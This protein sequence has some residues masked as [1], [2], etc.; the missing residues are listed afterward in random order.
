MGSDLVVA[1]GRA[2][3]N[4]QTLLGQNCNRPA[5]EGLVLRRVA[6]R[7]FTP[8]DT[9]TTVHAELPQARRTFTVLGGQIPGAWGFLHGVNEYRL[10]A[11]CAPWRSKLAGAGHGLLGTD[12]VRLILER[13]AGARQAVGVLTD[14]LARHGQAGGDNVFLIADPKEAF[15]VEAAGD[16]WSLQEIEQVRAAGD[17]AVIRQDW[18]R[19]APGLAG[20][21]IARGW[22]PEDGSKLDFAGTLSDE[23]AGRASALRRWGRATLLLE[24]QNGHI[25]AAFLRRLLADHYEGT[26]YE[27]DP[28]DAFGRVT[29]LCQH[30]TGGADSATAAS[31]VTVLSADPD[32]GPVVW[33]AFGPPCLSVHFPVFLDADLPAAFT[34]D[35]PA[36]YPGGVSW[37]AR[38]LADSVGADAGRIDLVRDAMG[39]LQARFEQEAEECAASAAALKRAGARAE[40]QRLAGSLMQNHL[41]R[42]D[43]AVEALLGA[44]VGPLPAP[45]G[46]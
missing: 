13:A 27:I 25:D 3:V 6:G 12:L 4:G 46:S 24:Q 32:R 14:L 33:C 45:A 15:A 26:R 10:A 39:R 2:T 31:F 41:E 1:L 9:L 19:I 21:V 34:A 18:N 42:F 17:V 40:L 23:P 29:P 37:L 44:A 22:W 38:R 5:G 43:E 30:A 16:A 35:A 20:R 8:D 11:G 36:P 28:L 7:S